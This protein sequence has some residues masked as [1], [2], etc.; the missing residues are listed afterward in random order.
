MFDVL[1]IHECI[2]ESTYIFCKLLKF[3]IVQKCDMN[4]GIYC[5]LK[6]DF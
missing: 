6:S 5:T 3:K 1:N 4:E 2:S